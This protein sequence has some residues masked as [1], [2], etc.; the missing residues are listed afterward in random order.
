MQIYHGAN[1][2]MLRHNPTLAPPVGSAF[3]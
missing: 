3:M 1:R 2:M